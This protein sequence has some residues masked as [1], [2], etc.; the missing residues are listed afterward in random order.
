METRLESQLRMIGESP[1]QTYGK[2]CMTRCSLVFSEA[3]AFYLHASHGYEKGC[4]LTENLIFLHIGS[5]ALN[6]GR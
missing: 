6:I 1:F 4:L 3:S 2:L 5:K